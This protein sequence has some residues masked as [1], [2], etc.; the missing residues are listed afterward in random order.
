MSLL[1]ILCSVLNQLEDTIL[2]LGSLC[3]L[4]RGFS[5]QVGLQQ[6]WRIKHAQD[7]HQLEAGGTICECHVKGEIPRCV[8]HAQTHGIGL[9]QQMQDLEKLLVHLSLEY[10][11]E[12]TTVIA[13][14]LVGN[15]LWGSLSNELKDF[16]TGIV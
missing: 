8:C 5:L 4:Q 3:N 2:A 14:I 16:E 12:G 7:P 13:A 10:Q 1:L 9:D 6:G 11:G 15:N